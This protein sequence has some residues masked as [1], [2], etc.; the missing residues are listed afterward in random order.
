[1]CSSD[2]AALDAFRAANGRGA[3]GAL[4]LGRLAPV[5]AVLAPAACYAVY[6]ALAA[7]TPGGPTAVTVCGTCFRREARYAP[8]RRQWSF[9][10]REVVHVGTPASARAFLDAARGA[11]D[12]LAQAWDLPIAV[13]TATDPFFD[14]A[15]SPRY[16]H[17][18]LFP[19][20]HEMVYDGDLAIGS[21]NLH[22]DYFGEAYGLRIDGATAHTACVAFGLERWVWAVLHRHGRD[23][24]RWPAPL[25]P[26]AT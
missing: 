16:L 23:P 21:F 26:T 7:R 10:M 24:S 20:K 12:A 6:P 19:A 14:P 8:L 25:R 4:A 2:L 18:K 11:V 5:D 17:Q 3:A 13:A 15:R 22:R 9:R 1:V